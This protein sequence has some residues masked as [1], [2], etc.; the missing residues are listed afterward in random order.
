MALELISGALKGTKIRL[1]FQIKVCTCISKH[2]ILASYIDLTMFTI[3][4]FVHA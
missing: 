4:A 1:V 2:T 3:V